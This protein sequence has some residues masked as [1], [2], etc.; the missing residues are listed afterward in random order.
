MIESEEYWSQRYKEN[1]TPWDMGT[2]SP[3]LTG[4]LQGLQHREQSVLIPGAGNGYEAEW[5]WSEGFKNIFVADISAEPLHHLKRRVPSFPEAQL[6]HQDFFQ[7]NRQFD[8][9]IEQTFFCALPPHMRREYVKKM[10]ELLVKDG[11]LVGVL[12]D[13]PLTEQGP[14]FGGSKEEYEELFGPC[15]KIHKLERCYN[16]I[17]PRQESEIFIRLISKSSG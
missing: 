1:N 10:S 2:A 15:F 12:F 3:P 8:L 16:S 7:L 4:F 17:K 9:I 5:L 6:L 14:P 13:F 11:Q